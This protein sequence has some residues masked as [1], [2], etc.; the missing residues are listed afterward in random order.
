MWADSVKS[1]SDLSSVLGG[2]P[3]AGTRQIREVPKPPS[4]AIHRPSGDQAGRDAPWMALATSTGVP[5]AA[6]AF[7]ISAGAHEK[8]SSAPSGDQVG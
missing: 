5:P 4:K 3:E 7:Q 6:G 2:P 1:I 8:A